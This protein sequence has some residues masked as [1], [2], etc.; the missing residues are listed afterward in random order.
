MA[1][2][3]PPP[4]GTPPPSQP[5]GWDP[6]QQRRYVR[7]Q[8]R[9]Q[10]A[11]ARAQAAQWALQARAMRRGSIL[12]PLLL[13]TVGVVFLLIETGK[14]DRAHFWGWYAQWWPLLLVCAGL[15]VLA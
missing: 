8:A 6:W 1:G 13:I 15:V 10:R 5:P 4:P 14:I 12:A 7:D 11:A 9:A 3:P 2:Y